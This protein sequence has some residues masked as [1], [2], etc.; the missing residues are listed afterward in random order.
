[1]KL[2]FVSMVVALAV[3]SAVAWAGGTFTDKP[4]T[5]RFSQGGTS[6][7]VVEPDGFKVSIALPDGTVK[8]D[9]VPALFALPDADAFMK[10]TVTAPDGSA[11]SKKVEIRA[12]QQAELA[13]NFKEEAKT[14]EKP[15]STR[16]FVGKV[17]NAGHTCGDA[18]KKP[19][20]VD[21][22]VG[23]SSTVALSKEIEWNTY[24]NLEVPAGHYDVRMYVKTNDVWDF[25]ATAPADSQKDGWKY[26]F[27]CTNRMKKPSL[28]A[29]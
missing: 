23:G 16:T 20:K 19:L 9:T 12:K 1:M 14:Q 13:V 5:Y 28:V 21:F 24:V 7:K 2:R 4:V 26:S 22:L 11:W 8:S 3:G 25:V 18:W 29:Q 10:V 6:L 17:E 27:G 15:A